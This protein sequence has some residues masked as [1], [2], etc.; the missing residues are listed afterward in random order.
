MNGTAHTVGMDAAMVEAGERSGQAELLSA[1]APKQQR[2][3][4]QEEEVTQQPPAAKKPPPSKLLGRLRAI[5]LFFK[6]AVTPRPW[7]VCT[8]TCCCVCSTAAAGYRCRHPLL[9]S[10][11]AGNPFPGL[12]CVSLCIPR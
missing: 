11:S 5:G 10:S 3:A 9:G 12:A 4:W 2:P 8:F 1:E 7:E 6:D